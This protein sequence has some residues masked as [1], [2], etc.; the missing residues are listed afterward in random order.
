MTASSVRTPQEALLRA[1]LLVQN[2]LACLPGKAVAIV[3]CID[4]IELALEEQHYTRCPFSVLRDEMEALK[5]AM[6]TEYADPNS[7]VNR[8]S[9]VYDSISR[10]AHKPSMMFEAIHY[11]RNVVMHP[12]ESGGRVPSWRPRRRGSFLDG[13]EH[14][15]L[16]V[17][18]AVQIAFEIRAVLMQEG[19]RP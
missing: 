18:L 11:L 5:G 9:L 19:P 16:G 8:H 13:P 3:A 12:H 14:T 15:R 4:E 1:S 6:R 2:L 10:L 7:E 17:C